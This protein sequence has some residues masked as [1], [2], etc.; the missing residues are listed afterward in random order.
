[1]TQYAHLS[2][3]LCDARQQITALSQLVSRLNPVADNMA[4]FAQESQGESFAVAFI[5][6]L[7]GSTRCGL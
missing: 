7:S 6:L 5:A 4:N 2:I 1:M 3:Q